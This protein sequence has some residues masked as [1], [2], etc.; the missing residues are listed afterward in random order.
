MLLLQQFLRNGGTI[1]ELKE[2]YAIDATR[3]KLYQNLILLKY[4]QLESPFHEKI[5]QEARGV[6]LDEKDSWRCICLR[7]S[8]F[9]NYGEECAA[10]IDWNTA[11]VQSKEDGS[12]LTLYNYKNTWHV[13]TSG[14]PSAS[15]SV[16]DSNCSFA[17]LFWD[18]FAAMGL[19]TPTNP[20]L[21]I[22]FELTSPFNRVVV[23]YDKPKLTM[24]GVHSRDT[25]RE[26]PLNTAYYPSVKSFPLTSFEEIVKSFEH[27]NP[28]SQEGYVVVD[29]KF[30]RVKVKH[31]GYVALHRLKDGFSR[32][33]VLEIV[34]TGENSE[35]LTYFPEY[36]SIFDE[37]IS[38]YNKLI[39]TLEYQYNRLKHIESQKDYALAVQAI[40]N[41]KHVVAGALYAIRKHPETSFKEILTRISIVNLMGVLDE[42][43]G[44][45]SRIC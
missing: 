9:F 19:W 34:R 14:E 12:L 18:T 29:A 8:R 26:L 45:R 40:P 37:I 17:T 25:L 5:V 16:G 15:G 38:K 33:R 35:F 30:N 4:N 3:H 22:S 39:W 21:C 24:I 23:P 13:A 42:D 36:K 43:T 20:D 28:L 6:I 11:Q 44:S 10:T 2:R 7:F 27:I 32:K 41:S 1:S 31:P